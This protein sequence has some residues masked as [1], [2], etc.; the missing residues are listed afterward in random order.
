MVVAVH[1][2][3]YVAN[4]PTESMIEE[5]SALLGTGECLIMF[6]EGT[7]TVPGRS[8][9]FHR[10]AASVAL[11]TARVVTPVFID[12]RPSHLSKAVPWYRVPARRPHYSVSVGPDIDPA[13]YRDRPLPVASRRLNSDFKTCY[14]SLIRTT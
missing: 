13:P 14:A 3:G 8:V 11:R 1:G 10:G 6:P 2:A 5:A 7:R 4:S 12:V 9:H